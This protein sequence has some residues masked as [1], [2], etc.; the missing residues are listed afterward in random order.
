[1]PTRRQY[2][3]PA[4]RQAAYR[5]R[6]SAE[7]PPAGVSL[8]P[9]PGYRRWAVLLTHIRR[10]LATLGE[11]MVAYREDRS[12]AGRTRSVGNCLPNRRRP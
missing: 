7:M 10:L 3:T 8:P 4:E 1:M 5:A 11:E 6:R 12:A 9:R 2:A